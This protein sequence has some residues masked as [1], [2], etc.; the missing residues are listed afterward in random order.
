MWKKLFQSKES[1]APPI[2]VIKLRVLL[3][4]MNPPKPIGF[5]VFDENNK[6]IG[7]LEY[8]E[9]LKAIQEYEGYYK[10]YLNNPMG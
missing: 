1:V 9:A 2:P 5:D 8:K 3:Q 10:R 4:L 6:L 7:T